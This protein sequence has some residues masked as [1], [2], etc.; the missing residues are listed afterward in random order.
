MRDE[1]ITQP[2]AFPS[3]PSVPLPTVLASWAAHV[4]K[5]GCQVESIPDLT[6]LQV[7]TQNTLYELIVIS[8]R[9]REVM[10]RGGHFF[11]EHT[12]VRLAGS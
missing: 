4:W 2:S 10:V 6:P 8:G 5:N 9:E 12:R 11:P 7:C 3:L 1:P